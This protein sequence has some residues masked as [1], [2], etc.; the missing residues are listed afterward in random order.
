MVYLTNLKTLTKFVQIAI[1][2]FIARSKSKKRMRIDGC[3][4]LVHDE[5]SRFLFQA[6]ISRRNTSTRD[7]G[8]NTGRFQILCSKISICYTADKK[9]FKFFSSYLGR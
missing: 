6:L 5:S 3:A 2:F 1:L 7:N 4:A 9:R 8:S